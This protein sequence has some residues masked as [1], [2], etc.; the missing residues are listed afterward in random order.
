MPD[1]ACPGVLVDVPVDTLSSIE[2]VQA[3]LS[4][5]AA[6]KTRKQKLK[7][8]LKQLQACE[9]RHSVVFGFHPNW[10]IVNRNSWY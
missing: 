7:Q 8:R 1:S 4:N 5:P 2:E 10:V 9:V 6:S 3:A